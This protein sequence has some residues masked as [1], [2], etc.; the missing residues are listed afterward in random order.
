M[1]SLPAASLAVATTLALM[2]GCGGGDG[3][4]AA[5]TTSGP[6]PSE[7]TTTSVELTTTTTAVDPALQALLL[8]ASD[9]PGFKEQSGATTTTTTPTTTTTCDATEVPAVK[10]ILEAPTANG[11]TLVK[12]ANDA[13][14]VSSRALKTTPEQAQSGLTELVDTKAEDCLAS[15]LKA[16]VEK[17]QPAGTTVTLKLTTAQST[18]AGSEQ[19]VI[20]SGAA[21][22]KADTVSRTLRQDLVFLRTAGT[23]VV[24]SY[25]GPSSLATT[26]ERQGIIV[27]A[28]AKLSGSTTSTTSA[29]GTGRSTSSTRRT[30]TTRR[31]TTST[32]RSSSTTAS[33]MRASTTSSST[34]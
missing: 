22:V 15:D 1:R 30:A 20:V 12:G 21:T 2:A 17:E 16:L 34:P 18:V 7:E 5:T 11:A 19:T 6:P 3:K 29:S 13:V 33:T 10:A 32:R 27:T 28:A 24:I 9:L 23:V 14:K 31:S 4:K 26:A 25:G 8:T